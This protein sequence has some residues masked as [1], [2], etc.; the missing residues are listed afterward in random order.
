MAN[1]SKRQRTD[2]LCVE[3]GIPDIRARWKELDAIWLFHIRKQGE[4]VSGYI[5]QM[6]PK[7]EATYSYRYQRRID[8]TGQSGMIERTF[9]WRLKCLMSELPRIVWEIKSVDC[10]RSYLL[11]WSQNINTL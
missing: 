3:F 7:P 8:I 10:L 4:I 6:I 5:K 1:Y 11:N 9:G 2:E